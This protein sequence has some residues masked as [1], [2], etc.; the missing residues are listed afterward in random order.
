[1]TALTDLRAQGMGNLGRGGDQ[2]PQ[3]TRCRRLRPISFRCFFV[4]SRGPQGRSARSPEIAYPPMYC[5]SVLHPRAHMVPLL[6]H[7]HRC[8]SSRSLMQKGGTLESAAVSW[9]RSAPNQPPLSC[10]AKTI[11]IATAQ[12]QQKNKKEPRST[13]HDLPVHGPRFASPR[14]TISQTMVHD[15]PVHGP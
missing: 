14:S 4:C 3:Q 7:S 15:L 5:N 11:L 12:K 13:V 2:R 10:P 6:F 8:L 1:M 9:A